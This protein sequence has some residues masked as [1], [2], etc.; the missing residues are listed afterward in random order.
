MRRRDG[1]PVAQQHF[2]QLP[3]IVNFAR[4]HVRDAGLALAQIA[5]FD[6]KRCDLFTQFFFALRVRVGLQGDLRVEQRR[7]GAFEL[8]VQVVT[9]PRRAVE[10]QA[11]FVQ[12]QAA[13]S[14]LIRVRIRFC[15]AAHVAVGDAQPLLL[16]A[17]PIEVFDPIER[18]NPLAHIG[19]QALKMT[20]GL[21]L[22]LQRF[23]I[24]QIF[25]EQIQLHE[26]A[27]VGERAEGETFD[28]FGRE[29]F[30]ELAQ[31]I[32]QM[33]AIIFEAR[34]DLGAG[35]GRQARNVRGGV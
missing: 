19:R 2:A 29:R 3:C 15:A 13:I 4:Q 33:K 14:E 32:E 12:F 21:E 10:R 7:V 30:F 35:A 27:D 18:G 6:F 23:H 34:E 28:D 25:V 9:L 1:L 8:L 20:Q 5:Q 22:R 26:L 17:F 11:H 24:D 16:R 31:P